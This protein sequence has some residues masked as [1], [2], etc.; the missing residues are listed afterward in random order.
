MEAEV[1]YGSDEVVEKGYGDSRQ[2]E[3]TN[4]LS[5]LV[6]NFEEDMVRQEFATAMAELS[7]A[8]RNK[9]SAHANELIKKCQ[10]LS[11]RISELSKKKQSI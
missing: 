7:M 3:I 10:V 4:A 8:E 9:D 1:I 6:L 11:I 2:K 5:E